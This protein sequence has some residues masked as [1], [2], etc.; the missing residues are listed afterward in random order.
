[1]CAMASIRKSFFGAE[2]IPPSIAKG[3]ASPRSAPV[4]V[5]L[6]GSRPSFRSRFGTLRLHDEQHARATI[7]VHALSVRHHHR[8]RTVVRGLS[9]QSNSAHANNAAAF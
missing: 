4:V 6:F 1:M 2:G 5:S 7:Q 3:V 8:R 9:I